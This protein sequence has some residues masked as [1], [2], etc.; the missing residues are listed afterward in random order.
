MAIPNGIAILFLRGPLPESGRTRAEARSAPACNA[1]LACDQRAVFD[2]HVLALLERRRFVVREV[3]ILAAFHAYVDGVGRRAAQ[4]FFHRIAGETAAN[5]AQ[6]GHCATAYTAAELIADQAASDRAANRADTGA[7]TFL[8]HFGDSHDGAAASAISRLRGRLLRV[9]S[10]LRRLLLHV[11]LLS[12]SR[13]GRRRRRLRSLGLLLLGLGG[14]SGL[15]RL[16]LL[17]L[18]LLRIRGRI[19]RLR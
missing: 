3:A 4:V 19:G 7:M 9:L 17:R 5:R 12:R 2:M 16:G 1:K 6:H 18:L 14:L 10:V 11:R 13:Y 8:T 15:G